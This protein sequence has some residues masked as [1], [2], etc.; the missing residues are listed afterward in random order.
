MGFQFLHVESYARQ[1]GK[2]KAGG[3]TVASVMAEA[4]RQPDACPH[5]ENPAPPILLF[6][7]SLAEVESKANEWAASST[8]AIGRKLRK[9]G[10]CLLAGVIS[11]PDDMAAEVWESM[12]QEAIAWLNQDGRLVSVAEHADEAHRH[13][14]FYK[15]PAPG[16]RF[17]TLHPGRAA[18]LEAKADGALRGE[19][20][21]A[22]KEAMRGFQDDFFEQVGARHGLTRLGPAKRRLTRSEWKN[23]Q[24][25]ALS[26]ANAMIKAD[27]DKVENARKANSLVVAKWM[28]QKASMDVVA[29]RISEDRAVVE[30]WGQRA[31][32]LGAFVGRAVDAFKGILTKRAATESARAAALALAQ[33]TAAAAKLAASEERAA[34]NRSKLARDAAVETARKQMREIEA[35]RDKA[36]Q[37]VAR[38]RPQGPKQGPIGP[39]MRR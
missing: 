1:A 10:L 14:H 38:L 31:G 27:A 23:E 30:K 16:A 3:H 13:V 26:L 33:K 37:E 35:E 8:D 12:K 36:L 25:A 7:C 28:K 34:A 24:V 6:G 20:N 19:Q 5:V 4:K 18:A 11:A 39:T 22:Y 32:L 2:G 15:I 17:E 29:K 21:R 9:D